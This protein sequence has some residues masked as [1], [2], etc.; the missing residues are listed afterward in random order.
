MASDPYLPLVDGLSQLV[1]PGSPGPVAP[2]NA[3]CAV[4]VGGDADTS[5]PS[6]F[7]LARTNGS[8]RVVAIC[9]DGI[10]NSSLSDDTKFVQNVTAWLNQAL[11]K[12]VAFSD[13][14]SEW[15]TLAGSST[16][17]AAVQSQGF[18]VSQL[19][20]P[21]TSNALTSVDVLIVGNAWGDFTASEISAVESFVTQGGGV[22]LIGLGWSWLAYHP[23]STLDDY[24]MTKMA[25]PYG[26][27]WRDGSITDPTNQYDGS[28]IF[29]VFYPLA[30]DDTVTNCSGHASAPNI[31]RYGYDSVLATADLLYA[32]VRIEKSYPGTYFCSIGGD[33]FYM[34]LQEGGIGGYRHVHFSVW[35]GPIA[36][37]QVA[38][39]AADVTA[40]RFGGEGT[41]WM[42]YWPFI[43]ETNVTYRFCIQI[44]HEAGN[45]LYHAY[46]YEPVGGWKHLASLLRPVAGA[47]LNYFY[48]FNEDFGAHCCVARSFLVGNEWARRWNGQWVDLSA[49]IFGHSLGQCS[50]NAF[51]ADVVGQSFRLETGGDT[52][53]D[54]D[55]G[56]VL[57]RSAGTQPASLPPEV[58]ATNNAGD[59][60]PG[61]WK[62][63]YGLNPLANIGAEDPD[64][65][66][67]NNLQ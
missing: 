4:I 12:R 44:T 62:V 16:Y 58:T 5:V 25:A 13:G 46:F 20:A 41:G 65:D 11:P 35:D 38:W 31:F 60:I 66:S 52:V 53:R 33:S 14:H 43:W 27:R 9:H 22:F 2:T 37:A 18:T 61:W 3:T 67:L 19:S 23:G 51:D 15:V 26:M 29:H 50:T 40:A 34:G 21:L 7:C 1:S 49:A 6:V 64:G 54:T 24:P 30:V 17:V 48:S 45:T 59:G 28:P 55:P 36:E 63:T 56:S 57:Y 42:T 32:E 10:V 8:G 39:K 47:G